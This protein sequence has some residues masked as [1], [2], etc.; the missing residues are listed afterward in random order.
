MLGRDRQSGLCGDSP[1]VIEGVCFITALKD[2]CVCSVAMDT[3]N[4]VRDA[5]T[6]V[7]RKIEETG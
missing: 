6:A 5:G 7:T 2:S 1:S 4:L 3:R